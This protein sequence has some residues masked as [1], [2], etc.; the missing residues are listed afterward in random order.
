MSYLYTSRLRKEFGGVVA[1]AD[2]DFVVEKGL[3]TGLMEL[4]KQRC[5]T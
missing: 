5:L 2:V 4:G 3:I 1:V